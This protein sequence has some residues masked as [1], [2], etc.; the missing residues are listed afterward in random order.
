MKYK[1]VEEA[2]ADMKGKVN[3]KGVMLPNKFNKK[4]FNALM[5]AM[6][7]DPNFTERITVSRGDTIDHEEI[8]VSKGFRKWCRHLVEKA[9][10]DKME[11]ERV[12]TTDFTIDNVDGLY[13]FFASALYEYMN[14]G[15]R[16]DLLPKDDFVGGIEL[17]DIDE[18]VRVG[19]AKSPRTGEILGTFKTKKKKHKEIKSKTKCPKWLVEKTK[20]D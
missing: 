14:A 5:L 9:G 17:R 6:I 19:T 3:A 12:M 7:N 13:D 10:M 2:L 20:E 11:S 15:N 4:R 18:V 8:M 16:F 1:T